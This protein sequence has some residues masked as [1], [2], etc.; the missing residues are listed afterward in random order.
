[1]YVQT[2]DEMAG[3]YG[4]QEGEKNVYQVLVGELG[5]ERPLGRPK[6]EW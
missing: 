3:G 6:H 1:V 2:K 5:G 4:S